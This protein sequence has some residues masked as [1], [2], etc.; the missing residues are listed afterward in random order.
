MGTIFE[1]ERTGT[2]EYICY[3]GYDIFQQMENAF[4]NT[5][6]NDTAVLLTKKLGQDYGVPSDQMQPFENS[7]FDY[8]VGFRSVKKS[9]NKFHF[10]LLHEFSEYV[11]AGAPGYDY[12]QYNVVTPM[13]RTA[14][15]KSGQPIKY[16]SYEYKGMNNYKRLDRVGLV[17]GIGAA[18][19]GGIGQFP[20]NTED[21]GRF[22]ILSEIAGH[23][24]CPNKMIIQKPD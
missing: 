13:G 8:Y 24:A 9:G 10:R 14:D 5:L 21:I 18:G 3:Q 15:K 11:G 2:R 12:P 6:A 7:D 17:G 22:G 4:S 16:V 23:F 20:V 19:E 1:Q